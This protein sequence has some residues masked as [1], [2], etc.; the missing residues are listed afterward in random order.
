MHFGYSALFNILKGY[1]NAFIKN[2]VNK[3]FVILNLKVQFLC[4]EDMDTLLLEIYVKADI[5][6]ILRARVNFFV[7]FLHKLLKAAQQRLKRI[8]IIKLLS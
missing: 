2:A 8:R 6:D 7:T 4:R 1:L 5:L 3:S